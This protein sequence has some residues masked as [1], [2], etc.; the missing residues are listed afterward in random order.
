ML[1]SHLD[2]PP[3]RVLAK[4]GSGGGLETGKGAEFGILVARRGR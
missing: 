3:S 4:V 1:W 2:L